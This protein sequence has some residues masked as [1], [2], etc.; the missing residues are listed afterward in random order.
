MADR[1]GG[2]SKRRRSDKAK[3]I[4]QRS[5]KRAQDR[6]AQYARM[7]DLRHAHNLQL[8]RDGELTPWELECLERARRREEQGLYQIWASNHKELASAQ[9]GLRSS[10]LAYI[11]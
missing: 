7:Q 4:G 1:Q 10:F 2:K 6:H 8:A 11:A 9:A 5:F 3:I